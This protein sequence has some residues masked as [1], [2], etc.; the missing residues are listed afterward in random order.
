MHETMIIKKRYDKRYHDEDYYE[1]HNN[2]GSRFNPKLDIPK[3]EG[4]M[5]VDDFLDWLKTIESVFEYCDPP[6]PPPPPPPPSLEHKKVNLVAIKM[7][8]NDSF[9]WENLKRK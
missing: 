1:R 3:F 9:W 2:G 6:P 8:K 5:H 7:R 4:R